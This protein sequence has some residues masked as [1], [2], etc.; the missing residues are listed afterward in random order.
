MSGFQFSQDKSNNSTS[1]TDWERLDQWFTVYTYLCISSTWS[2]SQFKHG[3]K[4]DLFE[5][6][7]HQRKLWKK[8]NNFGLA[9]AFLIMALELGSK[10]ERTHVCVF[11]RNCNAENKQ[12]PQSSNNKLDLETLKDG[13]ASRETSC[14]VRP[15]PSPSPS[16]PP[17]PR[18]HL[19]TGFV[20]GEGWPCC[21]SCHFIAKAVSGCM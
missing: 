16:P 3:F 6:R 14:L 19:R 18:F 7:K 9:K 12:N 5:I 8:L 13:K 17:P 1:G 21:H 15:S 4:F 2:K 20:Y 11:K 10:E